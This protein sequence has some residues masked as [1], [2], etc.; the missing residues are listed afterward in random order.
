MIQIKG[1]FK[2]TD[3]HHKNCGGISYTA[4]PSAGPT[5]L[6]LHGI[7]SNAMS[8]APLFDLLPTHLNLLAWN[9]PGYL[10]SEPMAELWPSPADY[11]QRLADLLDGLSI[12][13]AHIV[14]HSL[15]TL[16]AA[17]FARQYPNRVETL[18]LASAANGYRVSRGSKIPEKVA[19]RIQELN[20][21]G[22]VKFAHSRA[23]NLVYDPANN[24]SIVSR[25][26]SAMAQINP[27]GYTQAVHLLASGN[28]PE[29]VK[30]APICPG[31]IIGA[32]D[33]VTPID[34]THFAASGWAAENGRRP[35]VTIIEDAG[36]AVYLQRPNEFC[37][38]LLELLPEICRIDPALGRN[39]KEV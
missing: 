21:L 15:G 27:D 36:H 7:G 38:A 32:K 20:S 23:A 24:E 18:V 26:E 35:R 6:F 10:E 25:V 33:K 34:Q 12:R 11:A 2:V 28:L 1:E 17:A 19:I 3:L 14:G 30:H 37:V 5:V 29:D 22:P 8:F 39:H 16:I 9:A 4:R 31:F 13:T